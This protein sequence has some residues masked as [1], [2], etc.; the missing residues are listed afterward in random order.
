METGLANVESERSHVLGYR[1]HEYPG[2]REA[3]HVR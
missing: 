1:D 3:G 2:P